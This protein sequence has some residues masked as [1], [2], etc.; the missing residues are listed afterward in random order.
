MEKKLIVIFYGLK[1]WKNYFIF[2]ANMIIHMLRVIG[3]GDY[4]HTNSIINWIIWFQ[5]KY[6]G[7]ITKI[8]S[9][10][11]KSSFIK[12]D[13]CQSGSVSNYLF[14]FMIEYYT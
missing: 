14:N 6:P 11:K 1:L 3:E 7:K 8:I 9:L 4:N 5:G 12:N 13:L 2:Y 10:T